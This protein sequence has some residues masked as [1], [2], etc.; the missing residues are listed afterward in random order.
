MRPV[1]DAVR[2]ASRY[3][4]G[5]LALVLSGGYM[6]LVIGA[7]VFAEVGMRQSDQGLSAVTLILVT[8]PLSWLVMMIPPETIPVSA[9]LLLLTA[10]GFVQASILWWLLRGPRVDVPPARER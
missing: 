8:L 4:R 2:F 9:H 10:A 3:K 5:T 6:L 7:H 1:R